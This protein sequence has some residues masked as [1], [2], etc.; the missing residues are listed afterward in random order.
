MAKTKKQDV[1]DYIVRFIKNN[2]LRK[3]DKLGSENALAKQFHMSRMTIRQATHELIE[4]GIIYR[5]N[6]SGLFVAEAKLVRQTHYHELTSFNERAKLQGMS[7]NRKVISIT[8]EKPDGKISRE[9]NL[10]TSDYVY[11]I[12]RLMKF[13]DI[14]IT[15]EDFFMPVSMFPDLNVPVI[16]ESKYQYV[17]D[18]TKCSVDESIQVLQPIIVENEYVKNLLGLEPNQPVMCVREITYLS[19]G[20][21][22]EVNTSIFNSKFFEINQVAK[23]QNK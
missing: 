4:K 10:K 19:D 14:P 1:C 17:E 9:L 11:H 8:I 23:R 12:V 15:I 22:F 2:Q 13:D 5:V 6:G 3:G 7:A 18:S 20:T 16:E 21:P